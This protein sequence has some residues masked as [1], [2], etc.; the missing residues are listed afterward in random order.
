MS[1]LPSPPYRPTNELVGVAWLTLRVPELLGGDIVGPSLPTDTTKWAD[2]GFLQVTAIPGGRG[3]D[4]DLPRR[5]PVLQL[6]AWATGNRSGTSS[7]NKPQWNLAAQL[8]EAVRV[9][10]EDAQTGH[11]GKTITVKANY[12]DARVQAVYLLTEPEKVTDDPSGYARFTAD[13][14]L[15]W[16]PA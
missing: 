4:I 2:T 7:S 5:L 8:I 3:P 1:P 13:L 16:V 6:D 10:T 9:A 12:L 14:A 15:D 11:Y